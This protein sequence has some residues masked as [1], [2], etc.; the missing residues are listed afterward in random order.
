[1]ACLAE[2]DFAALRVDRDAVALAESAVKDLERQRILNHSLD[3][4]LER[5]RAVNRIVA[6]V[7]QQRLRRVG[8]LDRDLAVR[9]QTLQALQLN[10][11]DMLDLLAPERVED[12]DLVDAV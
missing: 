7:C 3:R 8:H 5:A 9:Q 2:D 11:D 1:M 10:L 12:H 4:A 6:P